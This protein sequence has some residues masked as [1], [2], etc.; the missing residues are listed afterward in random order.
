MSCATHDDRD[1][2]LCMHPQ[3][4]TKYYRRLF[5]LLLLLL[6]SFFF[7][8][9]RSFFLFPSS[10]FFFLLM[11]MWMIIIILCCFYLLQM[12]TLTP[13][14]FLFISLITAGESIEDDEQTPCRCHSCSGGS[15]GCELFPFVYKY[16]YI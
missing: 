13:P 16:I 12:A 15:R 2:A 9:V 7:F 1:Y 6:R 5:T 10:S 14:F 4:S 11:I 8:F 3:P